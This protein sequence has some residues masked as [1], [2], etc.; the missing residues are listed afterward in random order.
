MYLVNAVKR[1]HVELS[2]AQVRATNDIGHKADDKESTKKSI[3]NITTED[4]ICFHMHL[5]YP[6]MVSEKQLTVD[7]LENPLAFM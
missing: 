1:G 7:H 2:Y 3:G 4:M 6:L 5:L